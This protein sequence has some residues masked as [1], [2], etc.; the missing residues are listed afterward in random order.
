M[1]ETATDSLD[2]SKLLGIAADIVN[3]CQ[4]GSLSESFNITG[5]CEN[6]YVPSI[7][8]GEQSIVYNT[9]SPHQLFLSEHPEA[10]YEGSPLQKQ[11]KIRVSD[12]SVSMKSLILIFMCKRD[13]AVLNSVLLVTDE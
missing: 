13:T 6:V 9:P 1:N 11:P 3:E 4:V 5:E 12:L 7:D 2:H 8:T 10:K